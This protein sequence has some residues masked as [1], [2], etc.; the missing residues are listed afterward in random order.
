MLKR[1]IY[2]STGA[3]SVLM[4][5][6]TLA[7]LLLE[8]TYAQE[9]PGW[10]IQA[11][12]QDLGTLVVV[13]PA[14]LLT[15]LSAAKGSLKAYLAWVGLILYVIY[16]YVIYAFFVH[17]NYLFLLYIAILGISFYT[18]V[19]SL[20]HTRLD[21]VAASFGEAA[22]IRLTSRFLTAFAAAFAFLWLSEIVPALLA[23]TM[24]KSML[25]A[26]LITNPVY[27]LDL[28]FFFPSVALTGY[29]L[30]R[31]KPFGYF[32]T[33]PILAFSVA[34]A[35]PSIGAALAMAAKGMTVA[36]PPIVVMGGVAAMSVA[37]VVLFLKQANCSDR[38]WMR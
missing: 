2:W 17:F 35:L 3:L 9:A 22:P 4:L 32:F 25:E 12:G 28:A 37:V 7:G 6:A 23:G 15:G 16:A 20:A 36:Y 19:L 10:V 27:V 8:K 34:M 31:R 33:V 38:T 5:V 29:L 18:L 24:P 1:I 21:Q 11:I 30:K 26:G 14:L 13:I